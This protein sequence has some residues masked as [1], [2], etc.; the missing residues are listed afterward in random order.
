MLIIISK[1]QLEQHVH[2][3]KQH[4]GQYYSLFY[5]LEISSQ[6]RTDKFHFLSTKNVLYTFQDFA[7]LRTSG[8]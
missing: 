8:N 7:M 3:A 4:T 6:Y 1:E 5:Y 2:N